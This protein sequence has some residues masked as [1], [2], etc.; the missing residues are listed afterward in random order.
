[1]PFNYASGNQKENVI[2]PDIHRLNLNPVATW[3]V[4]QSVRF[5]NHILFILNVA[6]GSL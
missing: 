5:G 1:M 2:W 4:A 6:Q 3:K